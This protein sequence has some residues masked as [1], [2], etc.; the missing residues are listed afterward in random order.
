MPPIQPNNLVET[1][2]F[3]YDE[4]YN[5]VQT[6]FSN[7]GY[8]TTAGSN[9]SQLISAMT[10]FTSTLNV[11]TAMNI[12]ENILSLATTRDS[13]VTD[14]REFGYEI[15]H[16]QSYEY[17]LSVSLTGALNYTIPKYTSFQYNGLNYYY[18][19]VGISLTAQSVSDVLHASFVVKEGT[20]NFSV[21]N[22]GALVVE[23]TTVTNETGQVVPQYFI[24]IPYANVEENGIECFVSY[25]DDFG[26][27]I[28]DE[29]WNRV[30]NFYIDE[31]VQSSK[32]YFRMDDIAHQTPR[33][34]Y[35]ISGF[36]LGLKLGSVVKFNVLQTSGL[37]GII[38]DVTNTNNVKHSVPYATVDSIVLKLEGTAEETITSIKQNAPKFYNSQNRAV[39]LNDYMAI[40]NRQSTVKESSVWG[41]ESEFPKAPGH[42]WISLI[43]S[44][45]DRVFVAAPFNQSFTLNNDYFSSWN[46]SILSSD[47]AFKTQTDSQNAFYRSKYINDSEIVSSDINPDGSVS[48]PGVWDVLNTLKV[49]TTEFHNRHP[50]FLDFDYNVHIVKYNVTTSKAD[51]HQ[52]TFNTIDSFFSGIGDSINTERYNAQY[53][54]SSLEKR[55]DTNLSDASGVSSTLNTSL[56]LTRKSINTE[57][58]LRSAKNITFDL[59]VPLEPYFDGTGQLITGALP[60][61][62]TPNFLTNTSTGQP[63]IGTNLYV[64]WSGLATSPPPQTQEII[65]APIY[66]S[67]L[68]TLTIVSTNSTGSVVPINNSIFPDDPTSID[69]FTTQTYNNTVITLINAGGTRTTLVHTSDWT[70]NNNN[71]KELTIYHA[72][73]AGDVIEIS[74]KS[75]CGDYILFNS[76][77]RFIKVQLYIDA[78]NSIVLNQPGSLFTTPKS[79]L[80]TIDAWFLASTDAYYVTSTGYSL[81]NVGQ[82][83]LLTGA[84]VHKV[85]PSL[86][87]GSPIKYDMFNNDKKLN[88]SYSSFNFSTI[89][90]IVP[91]LHSVNFV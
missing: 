9:V 33:L 86:Y 85:S 6:K 65:T 68:E 43:Q 31:T 81:L 72:V 83:N 28:V 59:A 30:D 22:P 49:P 84:I 21:D 46:Y 40:C 58:N 15:K 14:A 67:E 10:Y 57:N 52:T 26:N 82:Q 60:N 51:I 32:N 35:S 73:T 19:G 63:I 41:G 70:I 74:R 50:I 13:V 71:R 38:T 2:P 44:N 61:I 24:D 23:T 18:L 7:A 5:N 45:Q 37:K 20:M 25:Y 64:D 11:N 56:I 4:I 29:Q 62:D 53:F 47:P 12:N 54:H 36:G 89:G 90:N 16:Q 17:T 55:V 77:K 76:Y 80:V 34:Y 66:I 69:L 75:R 27:Y 91:R 1:V 79:Y 87:T 42:V 3:N 48:N 8:D 39:T 88:M 78:S